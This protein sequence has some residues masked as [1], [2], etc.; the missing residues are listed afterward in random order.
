MAPK[1]YSKPPGLEKN[2]KNQRKRGFFPQT[3]LGEKTHFSQ[4]FC[5]FFP[6]LTI[7]TLTNPQSWSD[8]LTIKR[9]LQHLFHQPPDIERPTW[10]HGYNWAKCVP[11]KGILLAIY[12]SKFKSLKCYY[13]KRLSFQISGV[14]PVSPWVSHSSPPRTLYQTEMYSHVYS[15][16]PRAASSL[17]NL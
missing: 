14:A 7:S 6:G 1:Y 11:G 15:S 8:I 10:R 3:A 12:S 13:L 5:I 17:H 2:Q 9:G 4:F 16:A